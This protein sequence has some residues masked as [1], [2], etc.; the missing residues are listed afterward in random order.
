MDHAAIWGHCIR[1]VKAMGRIG[2]EPRS[3]PR[4]AASRPRGFTLI[5]LLVTI[6][7]IAILAGLL[8]AGLASAKSIAR[9][10]KCKSNLRQL[11]IAL[12][13]YVDEFAKFPRC[14]SLAFEGTWFGQLLPYAGCKVPSRSWNLGWADVYPEVFLCTEGRVGPPNGGRIEVGGQILMSYTNEVI[15]ASYGYNATGTVD[16]VFLNRM[17][18]GEMRER[19]LGL[20]M[21][22]SEAAVARPTDLIA[23][24]CLAT[25]GFWE[26]LLGAY[27]SPSWLYQASA[28]HRKGANVLFCDGHVEQVKKAKLVDAS[29]AARRRWNRDNE[30]HRETWPSPGN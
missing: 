4:L 24:G 27:S 7:I 17:R 13:M 3:W 30:P 2:F 11:G 10:A 16:P 23:F 15:H 25:H 22:C 9:S 6:A 19:Q 26:R 14:E 1:P 12:R 20:A 21:D 8:L 28:A 29:E 18:H 5:E